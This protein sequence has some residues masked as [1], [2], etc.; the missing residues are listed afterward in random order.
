MNK[1]IT[2]AFPL[3]YTSLFI[4][5]FDGN[6]DGLVGENSFSW[7]NKYTFLDSKD[8]RGI[9]HGDV[10]DLTRENLTNFDVREFYVGLVKDLKNMGL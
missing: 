3:N 4:K 8:R 2:G 9:S 10:I 7:G 1:V 5:R 6:N